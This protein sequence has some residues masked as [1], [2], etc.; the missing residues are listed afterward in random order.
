MQNLRPK[1]RDIILIRVGS[2]Q[3]RNI[4]LRP[5]ICLR[6]MP[7]NYREFLV[8]GLSSK[9]D[10]HI[11]GFDEIVTPKD[12][13]NEELGNLQCKS[14]IRLGFLDRVRIQAVQGSIGS[15]S[16]ERHRRLLKKL[17]DYFVKRS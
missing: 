7:P 10:L 17:S 4:K 6:M 1:E 11:Q 13:K 9:L 16:V 15:I 12:E 5:A 3:E 14:V 2:S 8:C